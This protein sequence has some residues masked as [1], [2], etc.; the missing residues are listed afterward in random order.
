MRANTTPWPPGQLTTGELSRER[1]ELEHK[2]SDSAFAT[3]DSRERWR[4]RLTAITAEQSARARA[5]QRSREAAVRQ[6]REAS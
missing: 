1:D 6:A 3:E 4:A 5:E 2:L